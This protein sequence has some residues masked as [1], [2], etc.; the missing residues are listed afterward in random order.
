MGLRKA[1]Q[2]WSSY[3]RL[4]RELDAMSPRQLRDIG[5]QHDDIDGFARRHADKL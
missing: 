3:S 5:L 4:R 2:K 1:F